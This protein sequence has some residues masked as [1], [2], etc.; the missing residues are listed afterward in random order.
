MIFGGI[1]KPSNMGF[2]GIVQALVISSDYELSWVI[3][4]YIVKKSK[5]KE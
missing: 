1:F 2:V 5:K 3:G 4:Q